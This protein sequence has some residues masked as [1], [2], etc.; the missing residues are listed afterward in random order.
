MSAI[1]VEGGRA[2]P[3]IDAMLAELA[4]EDRSGWSGPARATRV[5]ELQSVIDRL[6]AEQVRAV[7]DWDRDRAWLADEATS[8]AS[9][10]AHRADM[11]VGEAARLVRAAR[12]ARKHP[13]VGDAL[14]AGAITTGKVDELARVERHREELFERDV[15]VLIDA[16]VRHPM[17]EF[18]VVARR[19]RHLADDAASTDDPER[20]YER[21]FLHASPTFGGTVRIDGELDPDGG[22]A[23]LAALDR[24]APPDPVDDHLGPRSLEQRRADALVDMARESLAGT[25]QGELPRPVVDVLIDPETYAGLPPSDLDRIRSDIT[26][27]GPVP[28]DTIRRLMCDATLCALVGTSKQVLE[29]GEGIRVPSAAQRRAVIA[30]DGHCQFPGC[31]RPA[32]WCDVHHVIPVS[33]GGKTILTNLVLLCRRH[34]RAVHERRWQ[35][36]RDEDGT[37]RVTPPDRV[38]HRAPPARAP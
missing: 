11:P 7:G 19:W 36:S 4:A 21:R 1:D 9:W 18:A 6:R 3:E 28:V 10:L 38:R 34:H 31:D 20:V 35:L 26:S 24:Y 27:I 2:F 22:A 32:R 17:S 12:L 14:A 37:V 13:Q 15:P 33:V 5:L 16:A 30:R 23:F 25:R 29:M 8:G